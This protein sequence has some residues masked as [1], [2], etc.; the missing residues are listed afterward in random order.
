M[1]GSDGAA[2]TDDPF[3]DLLTDP[4]AGSGSSGPADPAMCKDA[5]CF[6]FFDCAIFHT[7]LLDCGF[8][9]CVDFV[10]VQ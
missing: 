5:F 6:D 3:G 8:T 7:D 9:D 10:C 2:G 1:S 4:T